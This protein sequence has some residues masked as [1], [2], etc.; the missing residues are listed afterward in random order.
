MLANWLVSP[1]SVESSMLSMCQCVW[2]ISSEDSSSASP[3]RRLLT[4]SDFRQHLCDFGKS[5]NSVRPFRFSGRATSIDGTGYLESIDCLVSME[6]T[7][8]TF[9]KIIDV[10]AR[11]WKS[12][13]QLIQHKFRSNS[14]DSWAA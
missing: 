11:Q 12:Q 8:R 7:G 6:R 1:N 9:R 4:P 5:S 14:P 10:V 3:F 2:T 13:I